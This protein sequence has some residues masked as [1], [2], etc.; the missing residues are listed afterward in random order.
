MLRK[1][2]P[3]IL[4]FV[5]AAVLL[6]AYFETVK[7]V[8]AESQRDGDSMQA[9]FSEGHAEPTADEDADPDGAEVLDVILFSE[10]EEND[11]V[12]FFQQQRFCNTSFTD[13]AEEGRVLRITTQDS[14]EAY[15]STPSVY[16]DYK[17]FCK[18]VGK[19]SADLSQM[20]VVVIKV[21]TETVS[22]RRFGL[23]GTA[24][25]LEAASSR[26]EAFAKIPSGDE[27]HYIVFDFVNANEPKTIA[28]FR[29]CFEQF[30]S[31][32]GE[33]VLI[34][35]MRICKAD[36]ADY[37]RTEETYPVQ[38][39]T[40]DDYRLRIM[41]F[42]VQTENGNKTPFPIRCEMFR[43][44]IDELI[45]DVV[46]M[47]EVSVAWS[48]WLNEYVFNDSYA[49][50][51]EPKPTKGGEM[52]SIYYRKDKFDLVDSGTMW[53]S[54][55]PDVKGSRYEGSNYPRRCTWV[56]LSDR[57]TGVRFV[58]INTHLDN[59]GNNDATTAS[60][61]RCAQMAV[62]IRFAQSFKDMP[63]FLTGDLNNRRTASN[64]DTMSLIKLISGETPVTAED[65]TTC[66]IALAD[67]RLDAPVTV[68][69]N[70]TATMTK[71]FDESNSVYEPTREPI[72]YVFYDPQFIEPLTYE[73]FLISRYNRWISDHLPLFTTFRLK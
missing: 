42:N 73:T 54:D 22:D 51:D 68:D 53:L 31:A 9:A 10:Q 35:E 3:V 15:T 30:A 27:W 39:Q 61:I 50:V 7:P 21:K 62:I 58:L 24:D 13:D 64:G 37:Y 45:P 5:L 49:G 46:G 48:K 60:S 66:T 34:S 19:A 29:I 72:D 1:V 2:L 33:S 8:T 32:D 14:G 20:P 11:V 52:T 12:S 36:E 47:Q 69:E 44:L 59:N 57:V 6:L 63:L 25:L 65:G 41:Q 18:S 4:V 55:T 38:L 26:T 40:A 67:S 43:S 16:F 70:H 28:M 17:G 56:V 71:Y 23:L